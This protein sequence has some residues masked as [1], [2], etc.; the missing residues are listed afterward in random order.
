MANKTL[1]QLNAAASVQATTVFGTW[2]GLGPMTQATGTQVAAF[3]A[4]ALATTFLTQAHNLSDLVNPATARTNIGLGNVANLNPAG[5]MAL[6]TSAEVVAA[7]GFTPAGGVIPINAQA[8]NYAPVTAD[9]GKLIQC[10]GSFTLTFPASA[11]IL[12]N[13]S[14]Y[15]QNAGTGNITLA[16]SSTD[17]IDGLTGYIIYPGEVRLM[18]SNGT[19]YVSI[20]LN[21]Y[22]RVLTTS[23][24]AFIWPPNYSAHEG[25]GWGGGEGGGTSS[26]SGAGAAGYPFVIPASAV[27]PGASVVITV[28]AS[29]PGSISGAHPGGAN[30]SIGSLLTFKG[31]VVSTGAGGLCLPNGAPVITYDGAAGLTSTNGAGVPAFYGGAGGGTGTN[32]GGV[33]IRGGQGGAGSNTGTASPGTAPGGGGGGSA[34]SGGGITGGAGARGE[35]RIGGRF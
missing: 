19:G 15:I 22:Y 11:S 10:T 35:I 9:A 30:S 2:D 3:L 18:I 28:A 26:N 25:E 12:S 24:A 33:S 1:N 29:T 14:A 27:T 34:T 7:L 32:A 31:S 20:I 8:A 17:L 23:D 6:M 13:W 4:A 21:P 16:R 5:I